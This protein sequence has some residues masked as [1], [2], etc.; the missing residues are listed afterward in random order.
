MADATATAH[1]PQQPL[2]DA[3]QE[4]GSEKPSHASSLAEAPCAQREP[5][6]FSRRRIVG[7]VVKEY[8]DY[9]LLATSFVTGMV[10][11]ASF[12]NWGVFVGM[13]TGKLYWQMHRHCILASTIHTDDHPGN[14]VILGLSTAGLPDMPHAWL[15][16]LVSIITFLLGAMATFHV[17]KYLTPTGVTSNRLWTSSLFTIQG[18]FIFV[19]AAIATPANIIPQNPAGTGF[20]TPEPSWVKHDIRIVSLLPLLGWQAGMQIAASRLLGYNEL[21]VNVVTSTYCDLMGDFKLLAT[22]NVKRN[23]RAASVILL[24]LG[25][26]V[27]AWL[28]R[29]RGGLESV[30]WVAGAIKVLAGLGLFIWLPVLKEKELP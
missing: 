16:T 14:T 24:F 22:N 1:A 29:S 27:S 17:S 30:L 7:P 23:R 10:D 4:L 2:R 20:H 8:G 21:P 28:M 19:A 9:G 5:G 18:L 26:I 25:S 13:Q 3:N 15:A 6:L 11:G 12:L